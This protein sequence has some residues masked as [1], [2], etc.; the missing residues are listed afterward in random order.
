MFVTL[1]GYCFDGCVDAFELLQLGADDATHTK[2]HRP[3]RSRCVCEYRS[4]YANRPK[5]WSSIEWR[6]GSWRSTSAKVPANRSRIVHALHSN[7][8][9]A[10]PCNRPEPSGR[11]ARVRCCSDRPLRHRVSAASQPIW[12]KPMK[13]WAKGE[14]NYVKSS[15]HGRF[16]GS[17]NLPGDDIHSRSGIIDGILRFAQSLRERIR[18]KALALCVVQQDIGRQIAGRLRDQIV[19][20]IHAKVANRNG[21]R[22]IQARHEPWTSDSQ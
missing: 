22:Q 17:V 7:S 4:K 12:T 11:S 15:H 14:E 20:W 18:S 13:S 10:M 8:C 5:P 9:G 16:P 2:V 3:V 19:G 1:C 21:A 6:P